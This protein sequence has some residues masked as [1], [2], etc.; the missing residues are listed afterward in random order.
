MPL[1]D[2]ACPDPGGPDLDK[3][4]ADGHVPE[5]PGAIAG[6]LRP[7]DAEAMAARSDTIRAHSYEGGW[8]NNATFVFPFLA[9]VGLLIAW[10]IVGETE[11]LGISLFFFV[12]TA[13]MLPLVWMTWQRTPTVVLVREAGLEALHQGEPRQYVPWGE[14]TA[15][16]RV[17]T[18]GNVRWYVV[19][20]DES[21]LTLEGEIADLETV[22]SAARR[23]AGLPPE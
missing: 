6:A 13:V 4:E 9:A 11:L 19:G 12:V 20:A 18:M 22:L 3:P 21:H 14:V 16:R 7:R 17:E 2:P 5:E 10:A 15:V 8:Y 1:L 23:L